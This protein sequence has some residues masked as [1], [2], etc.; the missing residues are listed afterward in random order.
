MKL[1]SS[2]LE[3]L[4]RLENLSCPDSDPFEK[5][6]DMDLNEINAYQESGLRIR[7]Y[8]F[9][10][11]PDPVCYAEYRSG[12]RVLLLMTKYWKKIYC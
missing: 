9:E 7:K 1:V 8:S 12:S 11:D 5:C 4:K 6:L 10:T 3:H 2:L